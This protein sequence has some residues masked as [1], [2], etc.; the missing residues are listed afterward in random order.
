MREREERR[1]V[2]VARGKRGRDSSEEKKKSDVRLE[3][4]DGLR[5]TPIQ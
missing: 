3:H 5:E 1:T 4:G 2:K